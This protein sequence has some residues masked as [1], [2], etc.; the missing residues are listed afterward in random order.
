MISQK[1]KITPLKHCVFWFGITFLNG[2]ALQLIL[3]VNQQNNP[4]GVLKYI[5]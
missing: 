2:Q 4:Q 1:L 5:V 3:I